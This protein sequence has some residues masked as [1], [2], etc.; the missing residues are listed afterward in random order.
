VE[1]MYLGLPIIAFGVNYNVET[2]FGKAVYFDN[3]E[4]LSKLLMSLEAIDRNTMMRDM[5][6]LAKKNYS[7]K[8]ITKKYIKVFKAL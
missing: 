2:T 6:K 7:W 1:A 5:L 4:E 3:S 8:A